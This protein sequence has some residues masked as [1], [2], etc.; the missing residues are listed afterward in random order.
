MAHSC[1]GFRRRF[2]GSTILINREQT[3]RLVLSH[4]R[5]AK[6]AGECALG[7][8]RNALRHLRLHLIK[9]LDFLY[10][11]RIWSFKVSAVGLG[12]GLGFGVRPN[13]AHL[14]LRGHKRVV[15]VIVVVG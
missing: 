6:V 13:L 3:L 7:M 11:G 5:G 10:I 9:G 12:S 4:G 14:L 2:L 1:G 15:A 8:G